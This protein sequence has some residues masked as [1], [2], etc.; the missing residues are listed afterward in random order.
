MDLNQLAALGEIAG[1]LGVVVSLFYVAYQIKQN[2]RALK[3]STAHAAEESF[4]QLNATQFAATQAHPALLKLYRDKCEIDAL[5]DEEQLMLGFHARAVMQHVSAQYHLYRNGL[6]EKRIW[7]YR[8]NWTSSWITNYPTITAWW[9]V[10]KTSFMFDPEFIAI[11]ESHEPKE[12]S[13]FG[14]MWG[15]NA[16]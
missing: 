9:V 3:G 16:A 10:E 5:T 8:L 1:G 4:A 6:L 14:G 15:K 2:T 12:I 13:D 7:E 11:V